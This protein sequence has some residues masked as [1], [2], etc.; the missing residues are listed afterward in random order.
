MA[1]LVALV[2]LLAVM[3]G[4]AG[5]YYAGQIDSEALSAAPP[6]STPQRNV[7]VTAV[8]DGRVTLR[9][10]SDEDAH[11]LGTSDVYGLRWSGGTGVLT[12]TPERGADGA[13]TRAL[14]VLSGTAPL[15]G[16]PASTSRDVWTDPTAAAG[17]PF[18]DVRY[19]CAGGGCPAWYVPGTS[20]TWMV[21]V[22]GKG[23]TREE[24][25]R[26]MVPAVRAGLPV[27]DISYRNDT[28]APRD[29]SGRYGYGTTEWHDLEQAVRW[30]GDHGARQVVL[31]GSS[32]GGSIVAAFLEHSRMAGLV[33]GVVLDAPALSLR[34]AVDRGAEDRSLPLGLPIPRVLTSTAEWIAGWHLGVDWSATDYLPGTWLHEPTLVFHGTADR[35]VPVATSDALRAAHPNLVDEVRVAGAD[36]VESWNASPA[37]YQTREAAFLD[38]VTTAAARSCTG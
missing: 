25:L 11:A 18:Q 31:F 7:T 20:S 3:L 22:H 1:A 36:H 19:A 12:G 26:A 8:A 35:T 38:C 16:A 17:V 10:S 15:A 27:L 9:T 34:A 28:G 4:V 6:S 5:W 21:M 30:A 24:P 23:A 29:P 13:S 37:T 2:L 32:M 33:R 14:Q